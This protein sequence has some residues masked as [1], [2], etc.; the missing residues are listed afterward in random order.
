M[1][2]TPPPKFDQDIQGKDTQLVPLVV[3][4]DT[5]YIS[6]NNLRLGNQT[7]LPLLDNIPSLKESIDIET[8]K[9]K[10]SNVTLKI[11]NSIYNGERF[12]EKDVKLNNSVKIYWMSPSC[13]SLDDCMY[14][15]NGFVR[16]YKMSD[17]MVTL[18]V[19]DK[20]QQIVHVDLPKDY[21]GSEEGVPDRYKNKPIPMVYGHVDRSPC[22]F[23]TSGS[24]A[25]NTLNLEII[26]DINTSVNFNTGLNDWYQKDI[27]NVITDP[28]WTVIDE[29]YYNVLKSSYDS[30]L[31]ENNYTINNNKINFA[32]SYDQSSD[33]KIQLGLL[34]IPLSTFLSVN[35]A[36]ETVSAENLLNITK[37]TNDFALIDYENSTYAFN[38]LYLKYDNYSDDNINYVYHFL[39]ADISY[40]VVSLSGSL[41]YLNHFGLQYNGWVT[42]TDTGTENII[43]KKQDGYFL[44]GGNQLDYDIFSNFSQEM[45]VGKVT[46]I[47]N[48][49]KTSQ[50]QSSN[51]I[52]TN[53][54][55]D[56]L[57]IPV[58]GREEE[59]SLGSASS[60]SDIHFWSNYSINNNTDFGS[61]NAECPF[62]LIISPSSRTS[63]GVWSNP[64]IKI[65]IGGIAY[66]NIINTLEVS[67]RN[68]YANVS[69]RAVAG[70]GITTTTADDQIKMIVADEL[71]SGATHIYDIPTIVQ[72]D[73]TFPYS[74][75]R[76]SFTVHENINSKKLIEELASS[77]AFIPRF[78]YLGEFVMNTIE[79]K[80]TNITDNEQIKEDDVIDFSY[81]LT[82]IEDVYTKIVFH[83]KYDYALDKFNNKYQ[84]SILDH[85]DPQ[86]S[87]YKYDYY[88]FEETS[89][90]DEEIDD[91][92]SNT[93]LVIDD[94]R[95]KYI[96]DD[97]T[98]TQF[99]DWLL[100]WHCNQHLKIKVT[101]PLKYMSVEVGDIIKFEKVLNGIIPY[102]IDYSK[103]GIVN[104][105]GRYNAFM[106]ISTDKRLDNIIIE[107]VQMSMLSSPLMTGC[108]D[109]TACNYN[110]SAVYSDPYSCIYDNGT[111]PGDIC[112]CDGMK[113]LDDCGVCGG[114]GS[115]CIDCAS[116]P[117]GNTTEDDC[118]VCGGDNADM[119]C[120]GDC[121]GDAL[122]DDN[123]VCCES[124]NIDECDICD[125]PG[126]CWI[127]DCLPQ[128]VEECD[129]ISDILALTH[130]CD[131]CQYTVDPCPEGYDCFGVC[132]GSAE[133]DECNICG[134]DGIPSGAC[135]CA[136]N[137]LDCNNVCGGA[138]FIDDCG[139]CSEGN[140]GHTANSDKDCNGDCFGTAEVDECGVCNAPG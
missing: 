83:Y 114:D 52:E 6:T 60:N 50:I 100:L 66:Y 11:H 94:H 107:C 9:Y 104:G 7:Y 49:Y 136:G 139:V 129:Q 102:G 86:L 64:H 65:K 92:I 4:D 25:N 57:D 122:V 115:S 124:G 14:I 135:D 73:G 131:Y 12:S 16:G 22:V 21:L 1:A 134:G 43:E 76:H 38:I 56:Y 93:T 103:Y 96:R 121:F 81:S 34:K 110:T 126:R 74:D 24:D 10:I 39:L 27:Y 117:N 17:T 79:R 69:G 109:P 67:N 35:E 44:P 85:F 51:T 46:G 130:H 125:G 116:V 84:T 75:W 99:A 111:Q 54:N 2:I 82:P 55:I 29:Q 90:Y 88:G 80:Y 113:T 42:L 26:S 78:N 33:Q 127:G 118:G 71:E 58:L 3:I 119:D 68:Y 87:N 8:R 28:L 36:F 140:T 72:N 101:L 98:A 47:N 23:K 91:H 32:V 105:Q 138:A 30:P 59:H 20:S 45:T 62:G 97:D 123:G 18:S 108:T 89:A 15:Y 132:G 5:H 128:Y 13:S 31:L 37:H 77:S 70:I 63:L 40:E 53:N 19:E 48:L 61:G 137:V 95:G 120:A 112:D 41:N 133:Y 106:V